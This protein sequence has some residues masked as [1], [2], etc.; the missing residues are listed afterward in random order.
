MSKKQATLK[1]PQILLS[2]Q[3]SIQKRFAMV[4]DTVLRPSNNSPSIRVKNHAFSGLRSV[5]GIPTVR[6]APK[7]KLPAIAKRLALEAEK[8]ERINIEEVP[9]VIANNPV[10]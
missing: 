9:E 1:S 3:T 8:Y 5:L 6:P 10:W 7:V 2:R 4:C